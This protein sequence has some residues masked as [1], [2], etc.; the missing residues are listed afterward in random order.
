MFLLLTQASV[1]NP[2]VAV[3]ISHIVD[4]RPTVPSKPER[5]STI[6][7]TACAGDRAHIVVVRE[8]FNAIAVALGDLRAV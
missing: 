6:F 4:V 2:P 1:N 7:T 5:G 8:E 3:N